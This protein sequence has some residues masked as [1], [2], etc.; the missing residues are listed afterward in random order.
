MNVEGHLCL[1]EHVLPPSSEWNGLRP[2]WRFVLIEKGEC[3]WVA[4]NEWRAMA[5]GQMIVLPPTTE[6]AFRASQMGPAALRHFQ[7]CAGSLS[8][9]LSPSDYRMIEKL[10]AGNPFIEFSATHSLSRQFAR[11]ALQVAA[12]SALL[13]R[14]RLLELAMEIFDSI[15]RSRGLAGAPENDVEQ[16][17]HAIFACGRFRN[18]TTRLTERELLLL[19]VEQLAESCNCSVRHFRALFRK[20]YGVSLKARQTR[21]RL[22][23]AAEQLRATDVT[24][25]QVAVEAGFGHGRSF[26]SAFKREFGCTPFEW[27]KSSGVAPKDGGARKSQC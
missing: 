24:I 6:V 4:A 13:L 10:G 17:E 14:C 9:I 12:T 27:R 23:V 16:A 8:G 7:V 25:K 3:Y 22:L 19:P 2:C 20:Q 15:A 21:V 11:M 26:G 5:T 1:S 18:L